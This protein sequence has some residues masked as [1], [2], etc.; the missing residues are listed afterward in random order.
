MI[1]ICKLSKEMHV[2]ILKNFKKK[3][4]EITDTEFVYQKF[5][6][7]QIERWVQIQMGST[8]VQF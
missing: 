4:P 5:K 3:I 7:M 8:V 6:D 1:A 2:N